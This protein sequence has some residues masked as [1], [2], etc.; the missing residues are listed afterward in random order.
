VSVKNTDGSG[1]DLHPKG[2]GSYREHSWGGKPDEHYDIQ[3]SADGRYE[4]VQKN[5]SQSYE[6]IADAERARLEKLAENIEEPR[7][8]EQFK[9]DLEKFGQRAG[10]LEKSYKAQYEK[11]GLS[12]EEAAKRAEKRAA[13][14]IIGTYREVGRMMES[15][16]DGPVA[17]PIRQIA[18]MQ[19]MHH[20][21]DP[22]TIDQG[23]HPTCNVAT[24]EA[25]LYSRSPSSI[26]R[27]VADTAITGECKT[28]GTPP[29]TIKLD[30]KSLEPDREAMYN[31]PDSQ[32]RS[33]ASQL[34]QV[35]AVNVEWEKSNQRKGTQVRYEQHEPTSP[36]D[37]GGR[38]VDYSKRPPQIMKNEDGSPD[39]GPGI[40]NQEI[41]DVYNEVAGTNDQGFV[42][43]R[44]YWANDNVTN[45]E[46]P[47]ALG[48]KLEEMKKNGE[49]PAIVLL[50]SGKEPFYTDS[51]AGAAGGSG[52]WHVV[53]VTDY[54]PATGKTSIDNQ[55]GEA[56]DR[57]GDR[58]IDVKTLYNAMSSRSQDLDAEIA[59][60]RQSGKIPTAQELE[61]LELDKKSISDQEFAERMAKLLVEQEKDWREAIK[62]GPP[63]AERTEE[64]EKAVA[65]MTALLERLPMAKRIKISNDVKRGLA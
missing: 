57:G 4:I 54:D 10:E 17:P 24:A 42:L 8:R 3:R 58:Q 45:V 15:S 27:L 20:A 35:A 39:E 26:A 44:P 14:E 1:Y 64:R 30:D 23:Q 56:Y 5:E 34:F 52:G 32:D 7:D 11:A 19:V 59:A 33:Y 28:R 55:W 25:R 9:N 60:A 21:A 50:H 47:D 29:T 51:G 53:T 48:K 12:P 16:Q 2:D 46:S 18:A 36:D 6:K 40:N 22:T 61:R 65:K 43:Q 13:E 37:S 38:L 62:H 63:N 41:V 49:L 31:P